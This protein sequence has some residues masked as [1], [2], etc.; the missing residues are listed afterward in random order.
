M[1]CW[2]SWKNAAQMPAISW[3]LT[4]SC[5]RSETRKFLAALVTPVACMQSPSEHIDALK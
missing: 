4:W 1:D 3:Q 5:H 2:H